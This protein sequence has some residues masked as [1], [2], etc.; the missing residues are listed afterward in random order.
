MQNFGKLERVDLREGWNDEAQSFTPWLAKEENLALLGETLDMELELEAK[1]QNVGPFSADILCKDTADNS[2]VLI[3][4]QLEKTDHRHIGQLITYA[5]GLQAVTI[6]WIAAI[7]QD[8]HRA[9]MDWLNE[10]THDQFNFFGLEIELWKIGDSL[11]APKFNI[12]SK[13]SDWS[14]SIKQVARRGELSEGKTMLERYWSTL[15]KYLLDRS[16]PVRAQTPRPQQWASFSI[17]RTGF[18][19]RA[20]VSTQKKQ[21]QV[22]LVL[23]GEDSQTHFKLLEQ[24]KD[25]IEREISSDLDWTERPAGKQSVISIIK[26]SVDPAD[27]SDRVNQMEWLSDMLGRFDSTFRPRVKELDA[28]DWVPDD[29]I[30]E[31]EEDE[32]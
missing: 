1:E 27:E 32:Q 25:E 15:R 19:M 3:E 24:D 30:E 18:N 29:Y 4:N 17:G 8:E 10:I 20:S 5:S 7:F 21:I 22:A 6:V 12:V 28:S 16:S 9:A 23:S 26:S 2:W 31:F 13:P 14:R 11:A